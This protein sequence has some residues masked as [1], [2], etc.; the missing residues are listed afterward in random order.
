MPVRLKC[1]GCGKTFKVSGEIQGKKVRC[2]NCGQ[3]L[4]SLNKKNTANNTDDDF[5]NNLGDL[6]E[7][8]QSSR[9]ARSSKNQRRKDFQ[10]DADN[11]KT[12]FTTGVCGK[13]QA[14]FRVKKEDLDTTI[15]CDVCGNLATILTLTEVRIKIGAIS[16]ISLISGLGFLAKIANL[17]YLL[18]SLPLL[19]LGL[20]AGSL[21]VF[22]KDKAIAWVGAKIVGLPK[23]DGY[24]DPQ[25]GYDD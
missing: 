13:C 2:R 15:R 1:D 3:A 14:V 18:L 8:S 21:V 10:N 16:V 20:F 9:V 7:S 25:D 4:R 6:V 11:R 5:L 23:E 24:D 19:C 17:A 22:G 12:K